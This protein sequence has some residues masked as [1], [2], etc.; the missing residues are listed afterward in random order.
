MQFSCE[1]RVKLAK[2]G[3]QIAGKQL[4]GIACLTQTEKTA[5]VGGQC[6]HLLQCEAG[7]TEDTTQTRCPIP[8]PFTLP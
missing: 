7:H 1:G 6:P 2:G 3:L 8:L 5:T 4:L